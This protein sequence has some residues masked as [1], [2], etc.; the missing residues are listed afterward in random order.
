MDCLY[1]ISESGDNDLPPEAEN[2]DEFGLTEISRDQIIDN[3]L[4]ANTFRGIMHATDCSVD[5][6]Y[7]HEP[8]GVKNL[9]CDPCQDSNDER[10]IHS[11]TSQC[12]VNEVSRSDSSFLLH[13]Y[14]IHP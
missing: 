2:A 10:I 7:Y 14:N 3:Q 1:Y 9:I 4:I 5:S 13:R 12:Y 8:Q 6:E 11:G